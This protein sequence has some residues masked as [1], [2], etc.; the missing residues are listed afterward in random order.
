MFGF[1]GKGVFSVEWE[2]EVVN[3]VMIVFQGEA[4]TQDEWDQLRTILD[5]V[6]IAKL[7]KWGVLGKDDEDDEDGYQITK[8]CG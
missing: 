6:V 7:Q 3:P 4:F 5:R 8:S 1:N 2:L